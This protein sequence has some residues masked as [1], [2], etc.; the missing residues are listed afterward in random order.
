MHEDDYPVG[1]RSIL[2]TGLEAGAAMAM[3]VC[4]PDE[5]LASAVNGGQTAATG[6]SPCKSSGNTRGYLQRRRCRGFCKFAMLTVKW[7]DQATVVGCVSGSI[8]TLRS[9]PRTRIAS[10]VP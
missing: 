10:H 7:H 5:C 4:G 6:R 8:L 9:G 2:A 3:V 1:K